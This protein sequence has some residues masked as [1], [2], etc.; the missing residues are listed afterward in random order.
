MCK[1]RSENVSRTPT[2]DTWNC[3]RRHFASR[4][5]RPCR[6]S[7]HAQRSANCPGLRS[8]ALHLDRLLCRCERRWRLGEQEQQQQLRF[9]LRRGAAVRRGHSFRHERQRQQS[10]GFIGGVQ[11]GYNY[12]FGYGSGFVIGGETD[13]DWAN[14]NRN[15]NNGTLFGSFTLP[16]F[17]G[18]LFTPSNIATR[19]ATTT[20]ISAPC[21]CGPAMP[22]IASWSTR[23]AVSPMAESTIRTMSARRSRRPL[24][25]APSASCRA[26]EV[27]PT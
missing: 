20:S 18:T 16:Q 21:A 11:A 6:G 15:K 25:P 14:I 9:P 2:E 22:G 10:S 17:P 7:S 19:T 24:C 23:Q 8:A 13:I 26:Q 1:F 3:G 12:Q 27:P 5:F 4:R